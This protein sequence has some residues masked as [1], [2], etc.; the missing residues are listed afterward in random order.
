VPS[1]RESG[2]GAYVAGS[3]S[4][5]LLAVETAAVLGLG[6]GLAAAV[7]ASL[8]GWVVAQMAALV[9]TA[10]LL[11]HARRRLGGVTGDVF[12]ALVEVGTALTLIGL[13]L[14]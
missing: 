2:F 6:V 13:A 4:T 3:V 8:V 11:V 1:A 9:L 14:S 7:D 10:G 5:G 12:G